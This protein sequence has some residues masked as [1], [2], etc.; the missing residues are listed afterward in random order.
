V[1]RFVRRTY[2]I[3]DHPARVRFS[4]FAFGSVVIA[5]MEALALGLMIPLTDLLI[6]HANEEKHLGTA[7]KTVQRVFN[8]DTRLQIAAV[9]GII[10]LVLFVVKSIFAIALLR[11]AIGNSLMQEARLAKRL[12][13]DFLS[14]PS[15]FHLKTNSSEIQR[16]LNESLLLVFRRTLPFVLSASADAFSL[17]AIAAIIIVSDPSVAAIA[18]V[19]FTLV[20]IF[21]QRYIGG[22]QK[23]A[24]RRAHR[25]VAARYQQVQEAVRA[26]REIA[27]MHRQD[28]FVGRFYD[29]KLELA[30]AQ[31]TLIFY[32]LMPR[33][34][35]D[36][37][38]VVGAG[39]MMGYAFTVLGPEKGLT[40]VGIYLT[41]SFRLVAPL[42]RIM[43][44]VTLART[45]DPHVDQIAADLKLLGE[46]QQTRFDDVSTGRLG[47]SDLAFT[48]VSF[49]YEDTVT[50]VLKQVSFEIKSGDDVGIV[51][52]TGAGKTTLLSILLG[53]LDPSGGSVTVS[54]QPLGQ[55][56][57]D[58]QLSIG[59][60]PQ[61]IVLIDDTMR[62]NIVFGVDSDSIDE[63][64]IQEV[65]D[66]AQLRTFIDGLPD[67]LDT[68]VGELGVRISGGQRQRLGLARA[69]YQQPSVLVLDEATSA[70]DS[71][72]ESRI[73]SRLAEMHGSMTIIS[74]SH[75][76]STLK[77]CDR[78]YFVR[79]GEI[80]AVGTFEEL[81]EREPEFAQLVALAQLTLAS[82]VDTEGP[83][84]AD[85]RDHRNGDLVGLRDGRAFG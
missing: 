4:L 72:T 33:Y 85:G 57:T 26:T 73:M 51:G 54:G 17:V 82:A 24:A 80:A 45:A 10:V 23:V 52:T 36:L 37:A 11:W 32:Q 55:C 78:I 9:L 28:Y 16:T 70:L 31:R 25:E 41:A 67:G 47:P 49:R 42:N 46:L 58:W 20:G 38:F 2:R 27:V 62:T 15:A 44:T 84:G 63:E 7:A 71:D 29:T 5:A 77:H 35:L 83:G 75:R 18:I 65:V 8:L 76:L 81:N 3:I 74:V 6:N 50:D 61:E 68:R 39:I 48:D 56:R 79:A 60:V 19:Y 22:W 12:F 34:F 30:D 66:L 53:L 69:L 13:S 14:A 21:Y 64:R 1:I 43:S 59:Y 40:T